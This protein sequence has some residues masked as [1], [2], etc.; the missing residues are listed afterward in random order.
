MKMPNLA[1]L[2]HCATG[3]LDSDPLSGWYGPAGGA[4]APARAASAVTPSASPLAAAPVPASNSRLVSRREFMSPRLGAMPAE[5]RHPMFSR[6]ADLRQCLDSFPHQTTTRPGLACPAAPGCN[7]RRCCRCAS[8]TEP[9]VAGLDDRLGAVGD[10]ELGDDVGDVEFART[11]GV[12][13]GW[14]SP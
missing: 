3:C 2:Y 4:W 14:S 9:G 8:G 7:D 10:V 12:L 13:S 6:G 5:R 11:G 1:S